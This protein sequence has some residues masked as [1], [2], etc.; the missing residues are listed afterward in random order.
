M[1]ERSS[2]KTGRSH[3]AFRCGEQASKAKHIKAPAVGEQLW[4][5]SGEVEDAVCLENL[6]PSGSSSG[7]THPDFEFWDSRIPLRTGQFIS[8]NFKRQVATEKERTQT[9]GRFLTRREIVW[10]MHKNTKISSENEAKL[11]F[12]EIIKLHLKKMATCGPFGHEAGRNAGCHD[13]QTCR[14]LIGKVCA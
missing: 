8:G 2:S 4:S 11:V 12:G 14:Q 13:L 1:Q 9:D 5:G 6:V 10:M 7:Y 3:P